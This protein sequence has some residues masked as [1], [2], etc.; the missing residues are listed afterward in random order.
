MPYIDPEKRIAA[1]AMP[2]TPGELNYAIT[3]LVIG[4]VQRKGLSYSVINDVLG[5]LSGA[6]QEFY[7]RMA[8]PYENAKLAVNGDVY[9]EILFS[10][11]L[12]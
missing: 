5:A 8:V 9:D 11:G 4:Y 3:K 12:N 1:I 6:G 10:H 2:E 7:R